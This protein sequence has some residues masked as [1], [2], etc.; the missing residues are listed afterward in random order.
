M[1]DRI[2]SSPEIL[3][4]GHLPSQHGTLDTGY[5]T[6]AP[7]GERH[8]YACCATNELARM[9]ETGRSCLNLTKGR[10]GESERVV[11]DWGGHLRFPAYGYSRKARGGGFGCQ[12]EDAYF[13]GP[14]G[15]QWIATVRGDMQLAMCKRT[16][17][18]GRREGE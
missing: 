3:E 4:C 17:R 18:I 15:F 8:C 11:T 14:D 7:T 9:Q 2:E 1:E 10:P 16:R 5:G 6:Y 13:T 12:R